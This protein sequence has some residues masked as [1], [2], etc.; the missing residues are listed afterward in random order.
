[1]TK[2][3]E[4]LAD[5]VSAKDILALSVSAKNELHAIKGDIVPINGLLVK[6]PKEFGFFSTV[7]NTFPA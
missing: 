3:A 1:M 5:D 2:L 7:L 4:E 6:T